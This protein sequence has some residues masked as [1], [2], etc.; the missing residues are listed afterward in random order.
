MLKGGEEEL[1]MV[2]SPPSEIIRGRGIKSRDKD[3]VRSAEAGVLGGR[4][5]SVVYATSI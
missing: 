4:D 2:W 5:S 3:L 1:T